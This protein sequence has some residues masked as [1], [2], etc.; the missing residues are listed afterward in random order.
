VLA[1]MRGFLESHHV[2]L[3]VELSAGDR[4]VIG[5][6]VLLQQVMQ[7][8]IMNAVEAMIPVT[9]RPRVLLVRTQREGSNGVQ[10]A[11]ETRA[12]G[13]MGEMATVSSMLSL[14]EKPT[15][16]AWGCR[17]AARSSKAHGGH[18]WAICGF[19]PW[20]AVAIHSAR[21]GWAQRMTEERPVV[22]VIDDDPSLR[23][24]I[25]RL[26]ARSA[27]AWSCSKRLRNFCRA[28]VQMRQAALC[29]MSVYRAK[30]FEPAAQP[31][32]GRYPYPDHFSSLLTA[33]SRCPS[34]R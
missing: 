26:C 34:G 32:C 18:I 3:R 28:N 5:D 2:A 22:I 29:S 33:T 21:R 11:V 10:V 4:P 9:D 25:D 13:S 30:R 15:G 27:W 6:R 1:L 14:R 20:R 7:N 23:K 8:L 31:N 19:A 17:S 16:W 12:S 24:A